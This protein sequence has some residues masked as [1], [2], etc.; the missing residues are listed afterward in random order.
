MIYATPFAR[1]RKIRSSRT[2]SLSAC[3]LNNSDPYG[4]WRGRGGCRRTH[5]EHQQK[6][7]KWKGI[8]YSDC[9]RVVRP[10]GFH[11][12]R[13][14][15]FNAET[16]FIMGWT[17]HRERETKCRAKW[18]AVSECA[19]SS[20]YLYIYIKRKYISSFGHAALLSFGSTIESTFIK[21][22]FKGSTQVGVSIGAVSPTDPLCRRRTR[23]PT[24]FVQP[25]LLV[26]YIALLI[27]YRL[28][29]ANIM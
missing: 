25:H 9:G 8:Y 4:E 2:F 22:P 12:S 26:Q 11:S 21:F 16:G 23:T 5:L 15:T 7:D 20:S 27:I 18:P 14:C 28:R 10:S 24:S 17:G 6:G 1:M 3:Q 19:T 29:T 13:V